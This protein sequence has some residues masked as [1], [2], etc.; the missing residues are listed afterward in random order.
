MSILLKKICLCLLFLFAIFALSHGSGNYDYKNCTDLITKKIIVDAGLDSEF[1]HSTVKSYPWYISQRSD[2]TF[3]SHIDDVV[4]K[5]DM[6]QIEHN[7]NCITTHNGK[8]KMHLCDAKLIDG[9]VEIEIYGGE[10]GWANSFLIKIIDNHFYCYFKA[11][12]PVSGLS[13]KWNIVS[14]ELKLKNN[15]FIKGKRIFGKVFVEFEEI[16]KQNGETEVKKYTIAGYIKPKL[17]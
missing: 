8:H 2:G 5:E 4:K 7:S 6:V 17:K 9:N 10:P 16:V 13:L 12:Y 11:E 1:Y 15:N 3:E 14:K